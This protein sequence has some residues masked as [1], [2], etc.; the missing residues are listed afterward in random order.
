MVQRQLPIDIQYE[1]L[2]FQS[3]FRIDLLIDGRLVVEI[4]SVAELNIA[5]TKQ[6]MT[7]LRLMKQPG[8]LLLNFGAPTLKDG[9]RRVVNNYRPSASPRLRVNQS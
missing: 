7:Y 8:G 4:K 3:A 1:G 2:F 5:H 6:L 9:I